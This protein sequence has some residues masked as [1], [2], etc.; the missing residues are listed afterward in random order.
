MFL[1]VVTGKKL[2]ATGSSEKLAG[3]SRAPCTRFCISRPFESVKSVGAGAAEAKPPSVQRT[4]TSLPAPS[5][6]GTGPT[7][8]SC[9]TAVAPAQR[10]SAPLSH[11]PA[12]AAWRASLS[13]GPSMSSSS[14]GPTAAG[15]PLAFGRI[16]YVVAGCPHS[17]LPVPSCGFVHAPAGGVPTHPGEAT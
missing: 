2:L 13:T 6:T 10:R 3:N 4:M 7:V 1:T 12:P 15:A 16:M 8:H 5:C 11:A 17:L 9:S 14:T